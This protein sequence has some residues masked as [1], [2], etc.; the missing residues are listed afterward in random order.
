M[1]DKS[2]ARSL[3]VVAML[4][5][6]SVAM[7][8][9]FGTDSNQF[10]LDFVPISGA[11]NPTSGYGIV[12][13]DYRTGTYEITNDQWNKFQ[14]AYGTVTGSPSTAYDEGFSD[15]GTGTTNVPTN[16]ISWYEAAQFVN[17]LNTST[18]HQ[19]AYN[20]TGTQGTGDYTFAAWSVTDTGYDAGNPYRN[21]NAFYFLPTEDEWVKAAY[22]NG[23][24]LQTYATKAGDTLFQGNGTNGGW[25]YYNASGPWSVGSGS[26]EL[27]GTYDMMGNVL[28][29]MESPWTS[30]DYGAS[31][32]RVLRGGFF[33]DR[34]DTLAAWFRYDDLFGNPTTEDGPI[35]GFR[36]ASELG[37]PLSGASEND[38]ACVDDSVTGPIGEQTVRSVTVWDGGELQ[39][40]DSG[41][42]TTSEGIAV[43][44]GGA[45]S[46]GG[47]IN[48]DINNTGTVT[49]N[50][51]VHNGDLTNSGTLTSNDGTHT[52]NTT[53]T[54]DIYSSGGT[55]SGDFVNYGNIFCSGG[56]F[57]SG[58]FINYGN[59]TCTGPGT[60]GGGTFINYGTFTPFG[61]EQFPSMD[62][63]GTLD[64][65]QESSTIEFN[66]DFSQTSGTM[67][68]EIGGYVQGDEYDFVHVTGSAFLEGC[69]DVSLIDGFSPNLGDA[70]TIMTA[71][72]GIGV[73]GGGLSIIGDGCFSWQIIDGVSLQLVSTV[74]EPAAFTLLAIAAVLLAGFWRLRR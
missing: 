8:D 70:F 23:T 71:D 7:A 25:N 68:A 72:G 13:N 22:W 55:M 31:S 59:V 45:I 41:T 29:W 58:T 53:N 19:A 26:E 24:A 3:L 64:L 60:G 69:I 43:A 52:G 44:P 14:A 40:P 35:G 1:Y 74:P 17:W 61:G 54:G 38:A 34:S 11:T 30:G 63:Q 6:A 42:L 51:G 50:G 47:T 5:I 36:V 10:M 12:N 48:G 33:C 39:M 56:A 2:I 32:S 9:V 65:G 18:G 66:G 4:L 21:K 49:S 15:F 20:F 62:N 57:I 28:E 27:N 67:M 46:G 37:V 16:S 73:G